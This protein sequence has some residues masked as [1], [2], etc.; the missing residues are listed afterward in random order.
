M[1]SLNDTGS[2]YMNATWEYMVQYMD[3]FVRI[4][5]EDRKNARQLASKQK[6]VK[7]AIF[8][9]E[10]ETGKKYSYEEGPEAKEG[11]M[12]KAQIDKMICDLAGPL[13]DELAG[14]RIAEKLNYFGS[15][16]WKLV[17]VAHDVSAD[18]HSCGSGQIRTEHAFIFRRQLT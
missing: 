2:D 13:A 4:T 6:E 11:F 1:R 9:W 3:P 12:K 14:K 15:R 18:E 8:I 5:E 7:D 16:G 17:N 10:T